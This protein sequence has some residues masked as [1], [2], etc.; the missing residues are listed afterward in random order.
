L[1]AGASLAFLMAGVVGRSRGADD[2]NDQLERARKRVLTQGKVC[3][4][5]QRP[6]GEFK[7]Y[8]LSFEIRKKFAFDRA[9]DRSAPF[10]AVMLKSGPL[11]GIAEQE[12]LEVQA[13]F[14]TRKVFV[15]QHLCQGFGDGVT[16]T[17][18]DRKVGFMAIY[19]AATEDEARRVLAEIKAKAPGR[20]EDANVRKMQVVRTYQLE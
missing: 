16:Y 7:P 3:P 12:R 17:N 19:A 8:E 10:F 1:V 11:C 15:H 9:E 14:P 20:F 2:A 4:D 5:P 18:A 6:C 13:L